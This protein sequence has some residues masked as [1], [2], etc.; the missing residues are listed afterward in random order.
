MDETFAF[1]RAFR[2]RRDASSVHQKD[3]MKAHVDIVLGHVVRYCGL[4][5]QLTLSTLYS[6]V[7]GSNVSP[8]SGL[9]KK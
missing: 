7:L 4:H 5:L 8:Y 2:P 3:I 6:S 1:T 9:W